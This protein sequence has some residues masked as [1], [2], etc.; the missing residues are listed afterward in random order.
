MAA[1]LIV[2]LAKYRTLKVKSEVKVQ[3]NFVQIK[4]ENSCRVVISISGNQY[5]H[6]HMEDRH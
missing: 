4:F 3:L 2:A 5:S 6:C 1:G